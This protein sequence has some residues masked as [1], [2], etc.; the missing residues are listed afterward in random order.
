MHQ[1]PSGLRIPHPQAKG[2]DSCEVLSDLFTALYERSSLYV[3]YW[4]LNITFTTLNIVHIW[5]QP[6]II[7]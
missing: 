6:S 2:I 3:T 5:N 4:L 1:G 7:S